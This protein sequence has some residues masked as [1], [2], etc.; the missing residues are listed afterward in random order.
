MRCD[1]HMQRV[2][3]SNLAAVGYDS[4]TATLRI[5][6]HDGSEY[7]YYNVPLQVYNGLMSASSHGS[8]ANS[9][10]YKRFRQR[11]IR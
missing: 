10:I 8:Y 1:M 3:S 6:F 9:F 5:L 11:K 4:D 2:S 7:E